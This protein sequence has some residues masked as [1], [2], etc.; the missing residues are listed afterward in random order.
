MMPIS[1]S[2]PRRADATDRSTSPTDTVARESDFGDVSPSDE[3]NRFTNLSRSVRSSD[4]VSDSHQ[5]DGRPPVEI[6]QPDKDERQMEHPQQCVDQR[7]DDLRRLGARP[8]G[9]QSEDAAEIVQTGP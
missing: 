4:R 6:A 9:R 5:L 2:S 7:A 8:H 3:S 1:P